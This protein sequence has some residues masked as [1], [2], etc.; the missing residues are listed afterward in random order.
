MAMTDSGKK[1]T[2]PN[3]ATAERA[4]QRSRRSARLKPTEVQDQAVTPIDSG[5]REQLI[6][7]LAK[8]DDPIDYEARAHQSLEAV[9][10]APFRYRPGRQQEAPRTRT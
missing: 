8:V 4:E 3:A 9:G 2:R 1:T 6:S 7:D 5:T 10:C